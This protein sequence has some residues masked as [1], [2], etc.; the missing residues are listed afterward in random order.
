MRTAESVVLACCPPLLEARSVSTVEILRI[1][2]DIDVLGLRQHGDG[3]GGSMDAPA[4]LGG[5]HTL[6]PMDARF[7]FQPGEHPPAGDIGD[8]LLVAAGIAL[9][10]LE[11]L[12]LPAMDV[13]I[14]LVHAEEIAGEQRRLVAA[15]PGTDLEDGT[16]LVSRVLGK[17]EHADPVGQRLD[18]LVERLRLLLGHRR[19]LRVADQ[20]LEVVAL[21]FSLPQVLDRLAHR[22]EL[23][24]LAAK[25]DQPLPIDRLGKARVDRTRRVQGGRTSFLWAACLV[26]SMAVARQPMRYVGMPSASAKAERG[27]RSPLSLPS[28]SRPSS[29]PAS[30]AASRAWV[31]ALTGPIAAADIDRTR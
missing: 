21:G 25:L 11:H 30:L 3:R 27:P 13:G 20:R 1:D 2:L 10:L 6:D 28:L 19:H 5:R 4:R 16:L 29:L 8:D 12:D 24:A 31:I 26:R 9:T 14:A 15:G 7:E 18:L 22:F 17:E 23:G